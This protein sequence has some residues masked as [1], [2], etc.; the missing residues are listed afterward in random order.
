MEKCRRLEN[1]ETFAVGYP[2]PKNWKITK[3]SI[4]YQ[5]DIV[6]IIS[7]KYVFNH[8][9]YVQ[10]KHPPREKNEKEKFQPDEA[11]ACLNNRQFVL[12]KIC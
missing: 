6:V 8:S 10:I 5:A 2:M 9:E 4:P 11:S 12:F 1:F 7:N 3:T